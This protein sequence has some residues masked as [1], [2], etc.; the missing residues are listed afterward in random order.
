MGTSLS[1]SL[2]GRCLKSGQESLPE[3]LRG[4]GC[5]PR[6]AELWLRLPGASW[7]GEEVLPAKSRFISSS[8]SCDG[9]LNMPTWIP[10]FST[11]LISSNMKKHQTSCTEN[12]LQKADLFL[13]YNPPSPNPSD[14]MTYEKGSFCWW[15]SLLPLSEV[16]LDVDKNFCSYLELL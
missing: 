8:D 12:F 15:K 5:W 9:H 6:I 2:Y 3:P 16:W 7:S 4:A 1:G 10:E 13:V 14:R 11:E